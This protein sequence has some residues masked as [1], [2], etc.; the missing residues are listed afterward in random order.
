MLVYQS[1]NIAAGAALMYYSYEKSAIFLTIINL[2]WFLVAVVGAVRLLH[3]PDARRRNKKKQ[4]PT[5]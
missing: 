4:L 3:S 5:S 2:V 1:V